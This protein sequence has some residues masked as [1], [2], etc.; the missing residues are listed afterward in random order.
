M[1]NAISRRR[2]ILIQAL[3]PVYLGLMTGVPLATA[4][5][6]VCA[7]SPIAWRAAA[8]ILAPAIC[9]VAY[10]VIAGLLAR[11]TR[12]AI[13]PGRFTRALG[14]EVYGPRRLY[15]LCW[16]AVYY[17][18]PLYHAVL[19]IPALKRLVFR[20]FGYR[21]S[22]DFQAYPDTWLRDLPLLSIGKG[23]YL[24]N[25]ATI[26]PNMCLKN[27]KIIVLPVTIGAGTMIGHLTMIAPGADIGADSEV[28]V[29]AAIGVNV[30]VG[31]HSLVGPEVVL[32]HDS[33]I[34]ERCIIGTR[35]YIGRRTVIRDG[36][37]VPPGAVIPESL[38]LSTQND[39]D[40]AITN[41]GPLIAP[42][43]P[44]FSRILS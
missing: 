25:K 6:L 43:S 44:R 3:V 7:V 28:G 26:S 22:L 30:C 1:Q 31:A 13:V 12:S 36:L 34:G 8:L 27:G 23:A 14:H 16:T 40:A 15:A 20:L 41:E 18:G 2:A 5:A 19:A 21:G 17:C 37:R 39:V 9:L 35:A 29:G 33:V 32:D 24:S 4:C 10:V 38:V 11:L 42:S